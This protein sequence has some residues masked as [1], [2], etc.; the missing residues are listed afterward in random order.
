MGERWQLLERDPPD[1]VV[2][3]GSEV[4]RGSPPVPDEPS[5]EAYRI[6]TAS[7]LQPTQ[8]RRRAGRHEH[9]EFLVHLPRERAQLGLSGLQMS[10]GQVP[11]VRVGTAVRTPMDEEDVT[12]AD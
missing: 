9:A 3:I 7:S 1:L 6:L 10:T 8:M 12:F 5:A 2:F 4:R 11:H